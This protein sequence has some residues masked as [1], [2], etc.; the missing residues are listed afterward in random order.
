MKDDT[1]DLMTVSDAAKILDVSAPTIRHWT[2]T[3]K[4]RAFRTPRGVR[5]YQR[6]DVEQLAYDRSA[7]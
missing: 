3:G 6:A 7:R 4:L 5:L 2:T 1:V